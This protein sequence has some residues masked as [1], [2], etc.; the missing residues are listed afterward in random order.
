MLLLN[1]SPYGVTA[2]KWVVLLADLSYSKILA[3]GTI[4]RLAW[5]LLAYKA[6]STAGSIAQP[7]L[8]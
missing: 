6:L 4:R 3:C 5:V 7:A 8:P 1:H 2:F